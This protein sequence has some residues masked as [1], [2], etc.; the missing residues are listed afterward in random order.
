ME[1]LLAKATEAR[2]RAYAPYSGFLVGAAIEADD[3]RIVVGCNVENASFGLGVC[4]ERAAVTAAVSQGIS[5]W[6]R[7]AVVAESSEPV[8]PCGACRQ[9]LSEFCDELEVILA[10][11]KGVRMVA[12]LSELLPRPFGAEQLGGGDEHKARP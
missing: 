9:V 10:D 7:I 4:A 8:A 11:S 6:R 2:S 1:E 3:G 12:P 5:G